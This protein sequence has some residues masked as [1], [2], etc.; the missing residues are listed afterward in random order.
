MLSLKRWL[1]GINRRICKHAGLS[2]GIILILLLFGCKGAGE[3]PNKTSTS[4]PSTTTITPYPSESPSPTPSPSI[5]ATPT[6]TPSPT[7]SPT[8]SPTLHPMNILAERET[9]YPGSKITI[10]E[11]LEPG[12]NYYRY[13]AWYESEGLKI[14]GLLTVPFGEMPPSGWPAIVFNHGYIS[15]L[16]YRTTQ[17]YIAY[18]DRLASAGYI[19]YKIDYRGHDQS[20]GKASGA[21]GD[22]GY[23]ADVLNAVSSL[24]A[25][26]QADPQ[27]I[28]MWGHSMGGYLT[29]RAMVISKDIKAGV[30][31]SGVVGSYPDMLCCWHRLPPNVPTSSPDPDY[32]VG[33]RTQWEILYGSPEDNP[34]F[35]VGIS[36][37]SYLKD[38]SGPIQLDVGTG[39]TDVPIKFSQ[40]LYQQILAAGKP[41]EYYEYPGDNHDLAN[42]FTLAMNRTIDFLDRYLKGGG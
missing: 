10:E 12:E 18:V 25:F 5:T 32:H 21:Y 34:A 8:P 13:Y 30:I 9:P 37:N 31:W 14:Y 42:H 23:T 17:R 36:T 38:L 40:D 15:P 28:G 4:V 19:V 27:R 2:L 22:P 11:T 41:V 20:E 26:P 7:I 29:L 3:A 1:I 16:A 6:V 35:W 24:K 33:W 39:D